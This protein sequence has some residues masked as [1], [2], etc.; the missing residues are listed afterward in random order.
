MI[1][2]ELETICVMLIHVKDLFKPHRTSLFLIKLEMKGFFMPCTE[3]YSY[4][5]QNLQVGL[6]AD[7]SWPD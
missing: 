3:Y 5:N 4:I 1:K 7:S 2:R 6:V